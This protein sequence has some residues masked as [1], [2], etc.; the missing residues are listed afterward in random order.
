MCTWEDGCSLCNVA[1][2]AWDS[3]PEPGRYVDPVREATVDHAAERRAEE[4]AYELNQLQDR[5]EGAA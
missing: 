1:A 2:T 4:R 3:T 5:E